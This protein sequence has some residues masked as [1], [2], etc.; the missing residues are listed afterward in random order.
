[1]E[2]ASA[3]IART[4]IIGSTQ[5]YPADTCEVTRP[6]RVKDFLSDTNHTLHT[7][8]FPGCLYQADDSD[9]LAGIALQ[10]FAV[11][12]MPIDILVKAA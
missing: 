9:H 2:I 6:Y 4:Y 10:R 11:T 5:I 12:N 8:A 1:M 3:R 7:A